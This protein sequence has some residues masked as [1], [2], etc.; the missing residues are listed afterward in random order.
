ME[1]PGQLAEMLGC[2]W[3]NQPP[4]SFQALTNRLAPD[5]L[6]AVLAETREALTTSLS[7]MDIARRAFDPFDL[8]N[9]PALTNVSGLSMEQGQKMFAS[10]EGTFR[11]LFVQARPDLGSY[12]TCASWLNAVRGMVNDLRAGQADWQG[13]VVRYTGPAGVCD[14]DRRGHAA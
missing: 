13:A 8:L 4:E 9:M 2:M 5:R 11:L 12:R 1:Q 6:Q 14:R 7:P 3:L 10:S